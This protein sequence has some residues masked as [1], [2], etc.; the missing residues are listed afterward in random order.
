[1]VPNLVATN[2][3]ADGPPINRGAGTTVLDAT[4]QALRLYGRAMDHLRRTATAGTNAT[5]A[6]ALA[7]AHHR[8]PA[9]RCLASAGML[10][11]CVPCERLL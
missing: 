4:D 6:R 11:R 5:L 2:R 3:P 7:L 8:H 10:S 1:M 9:S